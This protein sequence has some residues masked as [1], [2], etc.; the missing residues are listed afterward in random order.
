MLVLNDS[1]ARL[2][3]GRPA[4]P[5][6]T[7]S[8]KMSP[9]IS[10]TW[11][12]TPT[13]GRACHTVPSPFVPPSAPVL[14]RGYIGTLCANPRLDLKRDQVARPCCVDG[15]NGSPSSSSQVEPKRER[16]GR[17][18]TWAQLHVSVRPALRLNLRCRN[19]RIHLD[20]HFHPVGMVSHTLLTTT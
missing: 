11:H 12:W 19:R 2:L 9:S 8:S 7:T 1:A 16:M 10:R 15:I 14:N 17:P 6:T 13:L 5:P 3:I 4:C 18:C 20:A